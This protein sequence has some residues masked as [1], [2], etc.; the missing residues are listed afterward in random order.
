VTRSLPAHQQVAIV[1]HLRRALDRLRDVRLLDADRQR[2]MGLLNHAVE[3]R[4]RLMRARFRP[5]LAEAMD[6]VGLKAQNVPE[7]IGR[8]KLIEEVLDRVVDY[9]H[10]NMGNLRDAI[11]RNQLKMP[12]LQGPAELITGDPLIR[13]NRELASSL[14]GVYRRGE[15]YM[16][17]LHRISS[18]AF[19]TLI[20]RFLMLYLIL[21]F[22]LAFFVLVAPGLLIEEG[23]RFGWKLGLLER[24]ADPPTTN[25]PAAANGEDG[26]IDDSPNG[27]H[28]NGD[29]TEATTPGK[30]YHH[31]PLHLPDPWAW[32]AAGIFFLLLFHVRGF[33]SS[34]FYGVGRVGRG[35]HTVFI[36]GPV[37]VLRQPF[38]QALLRNRFWVY[39]RRCVF[40]PCALAA[41]GVLVGWL[42]QLLPQ[43]T[44]CIAVF[45]FLLGV[46]LLNTRMGRDLEEA[47]TDAFVRV[48]LWISVDF[49][50]GLFRLIMDVSRWCLEGLEQ[51][52]YT[53]DEWL[54]FRGGD[55]ALSLT[56]KAVLGVVWFA[57]TYVVRIY[58]NLLIEPT[59]NPIKHFPVV[60]VGHKIMLPFLFVLFRFLRDDLGLKALGPV[61]G[62]G[63]IVMTIFFIP[64]ICGFVVWELKEN[65]KL[66]RANRPRNLKPVMIGSHGETMTRLLRP[67]FHSGTVPKL[68]RKLR[69]AER[70]G[71]LPAV[72][73]I[74]AGSH[75]VEESV[76]HFV[77]RELL[78]L[79]RQS[80]GWGGLPVELGEVHLAT[81]RIEVAIACPDL[82]DHP[83][84]LAFDHLNGWLLAGVLHKGWLP[85]LT[86]E[87]RKTL[88][89][90]LAGLYKMAGVDLT[91]EQIEESLA[92]GRVAY[93]IT[94]DGLE[95]W[96][97]QDFATTAV[98]DLS[99]GP[100][101][102]PQSTSGS[103]VRS[104]PALDTSRLLFSNVPV[105][106]EDWT[107][108]WDRDRGL[109][110]GDRRELAY[111]V[112]PRN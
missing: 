78:A 25:A 64:G 27:N 15:I 53:V 46:L 41:A 20:G 81:N 28:G 1:R 74:M 19:G 86:A 16:R 21:P 103:P 3:H 106:W 95:V 56:T 73:N 65:W 9:G 58:A 94:T 60:T 49:V 55:N 52:L 18:A 7:Q 50:P 54:R 48:W 6:Q 100:L 82:D 8:D 59:V 29:P 89:A 51:V 88:A 42:Y 4:E 99:G 40:W 93:D 44:A 110:N 72:R 23:E 98:Y 83:L 31:R 2:L 34:L 32:A 12:D 13:L 71:R 38:L 112:L 24:P 92:P 67:G 87:Q 102:Q 36:H 14:D 91:R 61:F 97:T 111:A 66:Y 96:P 108:M 30:R 68:Y 69:R 39:L 22:G 45:L 105:T 37:W 75:H 63:F 104:L 26:I 90:G 79:L 10:L 47:L 43:T 107:R 33:R 84:V 101:L 62:T 80:R 11:A 5:L 109:V 35:L 17:W 85:R 57:I 76:G 70:R 77:E